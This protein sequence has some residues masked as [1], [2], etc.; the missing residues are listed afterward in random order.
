MKPLILIDGQYLITRS[1]YSPKLESDTTPTQIFLKN[2]YEWRTLGDLVVFFDGRR[3]QFRLDLLPDYKSKHTKKDQTEEEKKK[4]EQIRYLLDLNRKVIKELLSYT[5]IPVVHHPDYEGDDI[6]AKLAR[7]VSKDREV[8]AITSDSDYFQMINENTKIYRPWHNETVDRLEFYK[9]FNFNVEYY[10]LFLSLTG[11]HNSVPGVPGIGPKR[12]TDIVKELL[13]PTL[14]SL[15]EWC[16]QSKS[17]Q[18]AAVLENL[19]VV[20]RNLCLIDFRRVPLSEDAVNDYYLD[21]CSKS[22][23]DHKQLIIKA[24]EL[25][26][27]SVSK[28]IPYLMTRSK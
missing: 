17:K 24:S 15:N 26:I 9:K 10:S 13:S 7:H 25:K 23:L 4:S 12:A 19:A 18:S 27:H 2:L 8:I 1:V 5:G 22:R 20:K 11:T 14:S 3:P 16:L 28:F 21:C 6:I